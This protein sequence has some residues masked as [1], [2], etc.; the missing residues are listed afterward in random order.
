MVSTKHTLVAF[1]FALCSSAAMAADEATTPGSTT[2]TSS[3][4]TTGAGLTDSK[5]A[6][7]VSEANNV[8][9]DT[10]SFD[11]NSYDPEYDYDPDYDYLN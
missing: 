9:S 10:V 11:E 1:A 5:M 8:S 4:A 2:D 7:P 6:M 3:S